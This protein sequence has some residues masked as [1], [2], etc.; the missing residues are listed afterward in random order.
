MSINH[1]TD[2]AHIEHTDEQEKQG[3]FK[4]QL[5]WMVILWLGGVVSLYL[6]VQI[7]KFIM[8]FVGLS[9]PS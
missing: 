3:S 8:S 6:F 7:A 4:S 2:P 5:G 1:H 9:T